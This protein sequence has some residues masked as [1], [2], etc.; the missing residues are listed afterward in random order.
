MI[1]K[2]MQ[3]TI[4]NFTSVASAKRRRPLPVGSDYKCTSHNNQMWL[5]CFMLSVTRRCLP[6]HVEEHVL[7]TLRALHYHTVTDGL[8]RAVEHPAVLYT[9]LRGSPVSPDC[10]PCALLLSW[11]C[12]HFTLSHT[13]HMTTR[14]CIHTHTHTH[15]YIVVTAIFGE[16]H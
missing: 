14:T 4:W 7:L 2:H 15:T 5:E 12:F 1:A 6:K 11:H 16:I 10:V 3:N 13:S 9:G 8:T